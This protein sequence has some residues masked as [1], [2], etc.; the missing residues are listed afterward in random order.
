MDISQ[1]N[2]CVLEFQGITIYSPSLKDCKNGF[3]NS[4]TLY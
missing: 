2:D 4:E 1:G 3:L